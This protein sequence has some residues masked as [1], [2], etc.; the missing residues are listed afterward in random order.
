MSSN[1]Y[2]Y[3]GDI[4]STT[5]LHRYSFEPEDEESRVLENIEQPVIELSVS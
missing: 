5:C 3:F 2:L 1:C 4:L